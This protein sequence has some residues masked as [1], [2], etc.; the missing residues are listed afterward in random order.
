MEPLFVSSL[1]CGLHTAD[2]NLT[3][4]KKE[5]FHCGHY[6]FRCTTAERERPKYLRVAEF[7][8]LPSSPPAS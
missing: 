5:A 4:G 6:F 1:I 3:V 7:L 2:F 8:K